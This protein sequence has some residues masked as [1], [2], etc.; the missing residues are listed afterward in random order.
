MGDK[1]SEPLHVRVCLQPLD[2]KHQFSSIWNSW[3]TA[4]F[5]QDKNTTV[6]IMSSFSCCRGKV[7]GHP[8]FCFFI[9]NLYSPPRPKPAC[10]FLEFFS[11][12]LKFQNSTK[13]CPGVNHFELVLPKILNFDVRLRY[14]F[15]SGNVLELYRCLLL[16]FALVL[17]WRYTSFIGWLSC[18]WPHR[19]YLFPSM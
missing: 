7:W 5:L 18:P 14:F 10:M 4:F 9:G 1:F 3:I 11:L 8:D 13:I 6:S 15:R 17:L 16:S 12:T 19:R 2:I